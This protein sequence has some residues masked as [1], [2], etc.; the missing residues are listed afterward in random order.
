MDVNDLRYFLVIARSNNLQTAAKELN[1]TP[2]ALSK[3]IRRVE[4]LTHTQL[5]ERQ[6]RNIQLNA[7]GRRFC[8]YA[9]VI[10]HESEQAISAFGQGKQKIKVN[11]AGPQV[12]LQQALPRVLDCLPAA[13]YD[14]HITAEWE[15]DALK[16]LR[17]G[18]AHLAIATAEAV[19]Q[20]QGDLSIIELGETCFQLACAPAHP[21]LVDNPA[22]TISNEKIQKYAFACPV[23]SPFCGIQRGIG[24]DGWRDD[25]LPRNIAY[26]CSDFSTLLALV[27]QGRA[28]AYI[29]DFCISQAN[30]SAL[31]I[32]IPWQYRERLILAYQ[33]SQA[34]GWLQRFAS[35]LQSN[36]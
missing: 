27:Q 4:A 18:S 2:G 8:E 7:E 14:T 36:N 1:K 35:D 17:D 24:S 25:I 23:V 28:L 21:L 13:R 32:T 29:P 3:A 16:H 31:K 5:F 30:L 33:P 6:G 15:G 10:V 9:R 11:I 12:L 20:N 34:A 19:E 22:T 26:R